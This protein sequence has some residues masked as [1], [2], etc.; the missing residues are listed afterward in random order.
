[1][2]YIEL[3]KLLRR[4]MLMIWLHFSL[5]FPYLVLML[6]GQVDHQGDLLSPVVVKQGLLVLILIPR[7][8]AQL[9]QTLEQLARF[10]VQHKKIHQF[11]HQIRSTVLPVVILKI[12][13]L[14]DWMGKLLSDIDVSR[15]V[16]VALFLELEAAARSA[17][18]AANQIDVSDSEI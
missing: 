8:P 13:A 12:K 18:Y 5:I 14:E 16:H 6:C 17:F 7:E 3:R 10:L 2:K 1:M 9:M 11:Y 4:L 15:T